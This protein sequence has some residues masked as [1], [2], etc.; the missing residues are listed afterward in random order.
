MTLP[1]AATDPGGA[2]LAASLHRPFLDLRP[3]EDGP[4]FSHAPV[5]AYAGLEREGASPGM[6][7]VLS[8]NFRRNLVKQTGAHGFALL[9]PDEMEEGLQTPEWSR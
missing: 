1:G 6:Q 3:P 4:L 8:T 9:Q 5:L 2:V 7:R